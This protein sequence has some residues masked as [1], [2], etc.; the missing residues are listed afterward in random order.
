MEDEENDDEDN[1]SF[2]EEEAFDDEELPDD[3]EEDYDYD[4]EEL[5]RVSNF[6]V[7]DI[8]VMSVPLP[9]SKRDF[10]KRLQ[11]TG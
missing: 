8:L 6:E 5:G 9:R 10:Q 2:A 11:N 4:G 7:Y 1:Y 3:D